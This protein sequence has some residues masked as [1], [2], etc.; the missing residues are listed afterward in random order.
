MNCKTRLRILVHALLFTIL[1][2]PSS[3]RAELSI[4]FVN[5]HVFDQADLHLDIVGLDGTPLASL[6][7]NKT[8]FLDRGV[9]QHDVAK[10]LAGP[11]MCF[12][13]RGAQV[14]TPHYVIKPCID[15]IED[16]K[17]QS[18]A[19][20]YLAKLLSTA[21]YGNAM[22]RQIRNLTSERNCTNRIKADI[23]DLLTRYLDSLD[24]KWMSPE[25]IN[26]YAQVIAYFRRCPTVDRYD[27][28]SLDFLEN[29]GVSRRLDQET[30][31]T[32]RLAEYVRQAVAEDPERD[33]L[34][35]RMR[36]LYFEFQRLNPS[37]Y[38]D[39]FYADTSEQSYF[40]ALF[41]LA[42]T[43]S[44]HTG[45]M[46]D[47]PPILNNGQSLIRNYFETCKF[48]AERE[49]RDL[50]ER[51]LSAAV[52]LEQLIQIEKISVSESRTISSKIGDTLL[53]ASR[54]DLDDP[55]QPPASHALMRRFY[56]RGGCDTEVNFCHSAR[57]CLD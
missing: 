55:A 20:I 45:A 15:S 48:Y 24:P 35:T 47:S 4:E 10:W 33:E 56:A 28:L 36:E 39:L 9:R 50:S 11:G 37:P 41:G 22:R 46:T 19:Y 52:E 13:L 54:C 34:R 12:E 27:Y 30:S 32:G 25:D 8:T 18:A 5:M 40:K 3:A 43:L 6:S 49:R 31:A 57:Q 42:L 17:T 44:A 51:C 26:T 1:I 21:E 53:R 2:A 38:R 16:F 14:A 29:P 23:D 7:G